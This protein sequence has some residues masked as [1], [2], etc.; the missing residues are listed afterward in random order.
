[1]KN[2]ENREELRNALVAFLADRPA[3]AYSVSELARARDIRQ[4]VDA[5]FDESHVQDA[6]A[7]LIGFGLVQEV[8]RQLAGLSDYKITSEGVIF[9]ERNLP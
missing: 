3:R 7:I 5:E 2:I 6:L 9:R 8:P 1:M 4:S